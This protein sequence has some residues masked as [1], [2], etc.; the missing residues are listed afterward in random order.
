MIPIK[1]TMLAI[2]VS[3]VVL[4]K[5]P[6]E[7]QSTSANDR[8]QSVI[9]QVEK[10]CLAG[11]NYVYTVGSLR[12]KRLAELVRQVKPNVV[13]ECG[14]AIGYS[15]LWIARELRSNAKG[16]LITIEIDP[17]VAAKARANFRRAGLDK[18]ITL[19][20]GDARQIVKEIR[21]QVDFVFLDCGAEN[22]LP[23]LRGLQ[24]R[25]SD[26]AVIVADNVGVSARQSV[27]YLD[28][29]RS[30]YNS[31]TEWFDVDLPW[32]RRDAMEITFVG[33]GAASSGSENVPDNVAPAGFTS[34][35]NGRDFSGWKVPEGDGG[36]WKVIDGV[37]DYDAESEAKGDKT[38][39]GVRDFRDFVLHVDWRI[40]ETPYVNPRIPYILPDGTHARDIHGK[41]MTM[42]LPDSDS[43]IYLRGAGKNQVNIW[44][45]PIGSGEFYGYRMDEK[46]P[47]HVRAG[48]TPRTQADKPVGQWN[49]FEITLRGDRVT[50]VLNGKTVIENAQLPGIAPS[51]PIALQHHGSKRGGKWTSPPSLL[52]F[53]NIFIK[54]L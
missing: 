51:G 30:R 6:A 41:A 36:H 26:D 20:V 33:A 54:E 34:L 7:A 16:K 32:G 18:Y 46:Q 50:V 1:Y 31:H 28:F 9:E 14:S 4:A 23:C 27:E 17:E 29:V 38:L 40:K 53:K 47:P 5:A 12:A 25:L 44:C 13:V 8:I 24:D 11:P 19:K 43:G 39:W 21:G 15:G 10:E 37:I 48:V 3:A 52:Q 22:Y 45:W 49:R 42:A 2:L 35:F